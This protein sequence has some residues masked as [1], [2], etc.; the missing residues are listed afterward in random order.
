MNKRNNILEYKGYHTII[1][2]D[3]DTFKLRG[4]IEGINDFVN[5]ESQNPESIE[6]EF[7]A[8]VDDYLEFCQ[9]VGK[10]PDKE[11][12]G[13]FNIRI[14]PDLH[15][16]VALIALK[17]G[18]SLNSTIEKAIW[19]YVDGNI[20]TNTELRQTIRIL[21]MELETRRIYDKNCPERMMTE[22]EIIPFTGDKFHRV[23]MIYQESR[24]N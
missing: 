20:I 7:H 4:K 22:S 18:E 13:S 8:A 11:Y 9:E 5:F 3:A 12:K 23:N 2:F 6:Q 1:E 24:S 16:K 10:N 15:K 19:A 21:S 17:N 14:H